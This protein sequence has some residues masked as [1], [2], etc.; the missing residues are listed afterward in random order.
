MLRLAI[1]L[2]LFIGSSMAGAG[3]IA[4]LA[5]G[6]MGPMPIVWGALIGFIAA[7]P[8]TWIVAK[9]IYDGS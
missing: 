8:L 1:I 7:I 3:V 5:A 6:Y 2:H 9:M 4:V